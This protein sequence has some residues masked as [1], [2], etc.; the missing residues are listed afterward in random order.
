MQAAITNYGG[1]LVSL[2]VPAGGGNLIDVV[3]GCSSID[4][5][6]KTG[7]QLLRRNYWP[8]WQPYRK[9]HFTLDGTGLFIVYQQQA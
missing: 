9:G 4:G 2:L 3:V 7:G 1:R 5:Y 6:I 8:I